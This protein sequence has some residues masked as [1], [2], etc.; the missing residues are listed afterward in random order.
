MTDSETRQLLLSII[1]QAQEGKSLK[2]HFIRSWQE[3]KFR[4]C[5]AKST[6][7]V[8]KTLKASA[9]G[10]FKEYCKDVIAGIS[11]ITKLLAYQQLL[12]IFNKDTLCQQVNQKV[13]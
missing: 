6:K 10:L 12:D 2:F 3:F 8:I 5:Q 9:K 4:W 11:D 1:N 7:L 13:Y